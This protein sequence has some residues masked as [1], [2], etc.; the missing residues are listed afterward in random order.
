MSIQADKIIAVRTDRTV[1]RDGRTTLKV[2]NAEYTESYVLKEALNQSRAAEAG[3]PVPRVLEVIRLDGKW[4]IRS[5]YIPGDTL[6]QR[7]KASPAKQDAYIAQFCELQRSIFQTSPRAFDNRKIDFLEKID[8]APLDA[9]LRCTLHD[10]AVRVFDHTPPVLCH[11]NYD[12]SNILIGEDG[13][14]PFLVDWPRANAGPMLLDAANTYL[15]LL[16]DG[17]P[18]LAES[19]LTRFCLTNGADPQEI[20]EAIPCAA[21]ARLSDAKADERRMLLT[22][23]SNLL[24]A[25]HVSAAGIPSQESKS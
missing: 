6:R 21:A 19:Y 12:L 9:A 4:S 2:F 22:I 18:G 5:V 16:A 17:V 13:N 20:R 23:L 8:T 3:L 24:P 7:M 11:G 15:I 1:Y 14:T 10:R 25:N